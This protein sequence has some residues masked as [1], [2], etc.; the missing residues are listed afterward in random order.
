MLG[1]KDHSLEPSGLDL[2]VTS[3]ALSAQDTAGGAGG[4]DE[5]RVVKVEAQANGCL[6]ASW[7]SQRVRCAFPSLLRTL[8]QRGFSRVSWPVSIRAC[9]LWPAGMVSDC[10][11]LPGDCH[12]LRRLRAP[13]LDLPPEPASRLRGH[14]PHTV[15]SPLGGLQWGLRVSKVSFV[16][17]DFF[18][19]HP[20]TRGVVGKGRPQ[21]TKLLGKS[22]F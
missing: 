22:C 13:G 21:W 7:S 10:L 3:S 9:S 17:R 1:S 20:R 6:P 2:P 11:E 5:G 14:W 16:K 18:F 19:S 4:Q 15:D 12:T 8:D